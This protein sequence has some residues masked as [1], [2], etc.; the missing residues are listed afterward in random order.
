MAAVQTAVPADGYRLFGVDP[1]TCLINRLLAAS[2]DDAWARLEWLRDVYL[3]PPQAL[4]IEHRV[5]I[6]FG[7]TAV[8]YQRRLDAC[9]G[10]PPSLLRQVPEREHNRLFAEWRSPVGGSLLA[11]FAADD[12]PV[13]V[14]QMYRRDPARGFAPEDVAFV[15][16]LAPAIGQGLAA[17]LARE[18]ATAAADGG[19]D[20]S[21]VVLVGP[22]GQITLSTAP[23]ETW[24]AR[25]RAAERGAAEELPTAAW[26]ALA[27]V[28]AGEGRPAGVVTAPVPGG[29]LRVEAA[30]AG[31]DGSVA[32]VIA[33]VRP[34]APPEIPVGWGLTPRERR[35][36]ELLVR[37]L[38]NREIAA[39]L[40]VSEHTVEWHLRQVYEKLGVHG[41]GQVVARFFRETS[42]PNLR[43][44]TEAGDAES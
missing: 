43:A 38:G 20:A 1:A 5:L 42:W 7:A 8:A 36:V 27:A 37:G 12:R 13:A 30:P 18:H 44:A 10:Y 28:R 21:G 40:S 31:P 25:L 16:R 33:P 15:Q 26:A 4:L 32:L 22:N 41:R 34:P 29:T 24:L 19:P 14:L 3:I 6:R 35:L 17:A 11:H 9:L 39:A 23:G 2:D